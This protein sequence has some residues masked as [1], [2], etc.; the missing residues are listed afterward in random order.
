MVDL[1]DSSPIDCYDDKDNGCYDMDLE[2]ELFNTY[3][4][5]LDLT[6]A[7]EC[8]NFFT[9]CNN[10]LKVDTSTFRLKGVNKCGVKN[11]SIPEHTIILGQN[12]TENAILAPTSKIGLDPDMDNGFSNEIDK[13]T[14]KEVTTITP[15]ELYEV[16]NI[17]REVITGFDETGEVVDKLVPN[18]TL[19]NIKE[20]ARIAFG[21]DVD[22]QKAFT[23][24]VAAFVVKLHK[25]VSFNK[26]FHKKGT[27]ME[28]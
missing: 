10:I 22:Q 28:N 26:A 21:D 12:S 23:Q 17:D 13:H 25:K 6:E 11:V 24:L 5:N 16:H 9:D 18:G 15:S 7:E 14:V 4:E 2:E 20:Y 1:V 8:K 27:L 19:P 3:L